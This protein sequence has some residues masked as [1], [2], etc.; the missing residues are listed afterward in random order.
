MLSRTQ[1][2]YRDQHKK[3]AAEGIEEKKKKANPWLYGGSVVILIVIV[4]TFVGTPAIRGGSGSLG[5]IVFGTYAGRDITYLQGNYFAQQRLLIGERAQAQGEALDNPNTYYQVWRQAYLETVRHT[6]I[7]SEAATGG[8]YVSDDAVDQALIHY[9]PYQEN[10]QFSEQRYRRASAQ[11]K[12]A[13]RQLFREQLTQDQYLADTV[14]GVLTSKAAAESFRSMASPE[15]TFNYVTFPFGDYPNEK[16]VEYGTENAARFSRIRISRILLTGGQ[17]EARSI[18]GRLDADPLRFEEIAKASSKD[19]FAASGG[20]MGWQYRYDLELDFDKAEPVDAILALRQGEISAPL[21]G[22]YGWMIFRC[23]EAML[24]IDPTRE[25][26]RQ[27]IRT[28]LDRYEAGL[29][30]D[31]FLERAKAFVLRARTEGLAQTA[32]ADGLIVD[33]TSSFPMNYQNI[34]Y[35]KGVQPQDQAG[36]GGTNPLADALYSEE[37]FTQAFSL[38]MGE[39]SEPVVLGDKVVVLALRGEQGAADTDL[40][41]M[42]DYYRYLSQQSLAADLESV[43]L[44]EDRFVDR[45]DQT[46]EQYLAPSGS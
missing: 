20:S 27:T 42:D 10:G 33:T 9:G 11:D 1:R 12:F 31:Y 36:T 30:Q 34:F 5:G 43:L 16:I 3:N 8:L 38:G 21:E 15:R 41:L 7:L 13:T 40:D 14:T 17:N 44:D 25:E 28:Y 22:K 35:L 32:S 18:K 46:Y 4:V 19:A 45:F 6:A 2:R 24:P 26:D 37:F 23:D 39:I 29:V